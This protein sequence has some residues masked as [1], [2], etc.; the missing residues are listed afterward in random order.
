MGDA[1]VHASPV[2]KRYDT[3]EALAAVGGHH[4]RIHLH[5]RGREKRRE[6]EQAGRQGS[7]ATLQ[8]SYKHGLR[9]HLD[10]TTSSHSSQTRLFRSGSPTP[11]I[12]SSMSNNRGE[13]APQSPDEVNSKEKGRGRGLFGILGGRSKDKD[14]GADN[15]RSLK[16]KASEP[17]L[18][19]GTSSSAVSDTK[20]RGGS[21]GEHITPRA[22]EFASVAELAAKKK[23][24][25]SRRGF[26]DTGKDP[27][28]MGRRS[29]NGNSSNPMEYR[30]D[31]SFADQAS[32]LKQGVETQLPEAVSWEPPES[33]AT[34]GMD[35]AG[36]IAPDEE[37]NDES[38]R[39]DSHTVRSLRTKHVDTPLTGYSIAFG[40]SVR[41]PPSPP[42]P[43][44]CLLQ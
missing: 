42:S 15:K 4:H 38:G 6:K 8:D 44:N 34:L 21:S 28:G 31:T 11:S 25:A 10:G 35:P 20:P 33:W 13:A 9:L 1:P 14:K 37:P 41:T 7:N 19:S 39:E 26:S 23:A 18:N 3:D 12:A 24:D 32:W 40:Y 29:K 43:A 36:D 27:R 22:F 5:H 16:P 30:L 2:E 17:M